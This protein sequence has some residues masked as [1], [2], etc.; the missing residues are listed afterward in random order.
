MEKQNYNCPLWLSFLNEVFENDEDLINYVQMLVG[1]LLSKYNV[2]QKLYALFG[3]GANGKSVFAEILIKLAGDKIAM[4]PKDILTKK[5]YQLKYE[6]Y[7]MLKNAHIAL[8]AEPSKDDKFYLSTIKKLTG[9][10]TL[11]VYD[12]ENKKIVKFKLRTKLLFMS[13]YIPEFKDEGYAVDRRFEIIPFNRT[14]QPFEIDKLKLYRLLKEIDEIR[15]WADEGLEKYKRTL[16]FKVPDAIEKAKID[17]WKSKTDPKFHP[18]VDCL[19]R[20]YNAGMTIYDIYHFGKNLDYF[21][22]DFWKVPQNQLMMGKLLTKLSVSKPEMIMRNKVYTGI[23]I[24]NDARTQKYIEQYGDFSYKSQTERI[25]KIK[26]W[27]SNEDELITAFYQ[28]M[29]ANYEKALKDKNDLIISQDNDESCND[30]TE[31]ETVTNSLHSD[32]NYTQA[33]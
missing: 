17:E 31:S 2:E 12:P 11:T 18:I 26:V 32:E 3:T 5:D 23:N 19:R 15:K 16:Y 25:K 27:N 1:M 13:N 33:E 10:D 30:S 22:D 21:F 6:D 8:I 9:G 29:Q 14:F 28:K 4:I 20:D 7:L 24:V